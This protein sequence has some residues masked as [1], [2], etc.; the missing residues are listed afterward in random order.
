MM[1]KKNALSVLMLLGL[2]EVCA[3]NTIR[4]YVLQIE[5]NKIYLDVTAPV[6]K[7]GDVLSVYS[8]AGY[9]IHPVTK[10]KI[11]KEGEILVDLE[12]IEIKNEYSVA[13][14][15]PENAIS[16]IKEG[17]VAIMP[18][19]REE[20]ANTDVLVNV[21]TSKSNLKPVFNT[22]ADVI[23]WHRERSG[24][25]NLKNTDSCACLIENVVT[26]L[27]KKGKIQYTLH[28]VVIVQALSQKGYVK[29]NV[30]MEI[31]GPDINTTS[32]C[33]VNGNNGWEKTNG[34]KTKIMKVSRLNEMK[35]ALQDPLNDVYLNNRYNNQL[36]GC[37]YVEDKYCVGISIEDI[38]EGGLYKNF[39]DL[40]S[41]LLVATF[42]TLNGEDEVVAKV[43]ENQNF[44]GIIRPS[45][46]E[47]VGKK[48]IVTTEKIIRFIPNYPLDNIS[49]TAEDIDRNF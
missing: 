27:N 13:S 40:E 47:T 26:Q 44:N 35:K 21:D 4:S 34:G 32:I 31:M 33:V 15:Y 41:G 43:K 16:K 29:S 1:I 7:K 37:Q 18:K 39:Y 24:Y 25:N 42:I 22:P 14:V 45:V 19:I 2:L 30:K 5:G 36:L 38:E 9:I 12:I 46:I 3:Q 17:M 28:S 48:G 11:P 49:F 23:M 20:V 10:K 6:V 8:E